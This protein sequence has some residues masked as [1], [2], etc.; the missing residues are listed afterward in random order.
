MAAGDFN[1][2]IW[3]KDVLKN[4]DEKF[5]IVSCTNQEHEKDVK[6]DGDTVIVFV[7]GD[8][9][10]NTYSGTVTYETPSQGNES[11]ALDQ[12]KYWAFNVPDIDKVQSRPN[13]RKL[14]TKRADVAYKR[15]VEQYLLGASII[16]AAGNEVIAKTTGG[17]TGGALTASNV[18]T[19]LNRA[20]RLM[21]DDNTWVDGEMWL[22]VPPVVTEMIRNSNELIHATEKGDQF[23]KSG[24]VTKLAGWNLLQVD[25]GN[26]QGAGT[27]GDP[28]HM[29]GGNKDAINFVQQIKEM[30]GIRRDG[31]F[32]T[33]VRGLFV[34]G[35]KIFTQNTNA[36]CIVT[37]EV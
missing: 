24:T 15:N 34:Y 14:Y 26:M 8:I 6:S 20:R 23:I 31:S 27:D 18:Y 3:T 4:W 7:V 2:E 35:A 30:E 21:E 25:V 12:D 37:V 5:P 19:V 29:V 13:I 22:G 11:M 10:V 33:G 28:Y 17:I 1:P 36:A 32:A 16:A 9:T